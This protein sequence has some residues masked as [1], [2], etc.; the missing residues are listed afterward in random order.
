MNSRVYITAEFEFKDLHIT[1]YSVVSHLIVE[2]IVTKINHFYTIT[3]SQLLW[4][5]AVT[6][7]SFICVNLNVPKCIFFVL[8]TIYEKISPRPL[9]V[10]YHAG[11]SA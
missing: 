4:E 1:P 5:D 2:L 6:R 10:L 7:S 9:Y 8:I 11:T 3:L